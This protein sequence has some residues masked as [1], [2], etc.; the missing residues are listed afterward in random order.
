VVKAAQTP[1]EFDGA[2]PRR[3]QRLLG[4]GMGVVLVSLLSLPA[5]A[6]AA[7]PEL[8][9]PVLTEVA[10]MAASVVPAGVQPTSAPA[11][12][13]SAPA[14]TSTAVPVPADQ[15]SAPAASVAD[16]QP[17]AVATPQAS[18][19]VA[20]S[21]QAVASVPV[22]SPEGTTAGTGGVL[23]R[24]GRRA[25]APV[26]STRRSPSHVR[27][28]AVVHARRSGF[29]LRPAASAAPP[30]ELSQTAT[31]PSSLVAALSPL[32]ASAPLTGAG[33]LVTLILLLGGALLIAL[34]C[35]D[36]VGTGPRHDYLR[37]QAAH[38]WPPWR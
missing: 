15:P 30:L 24:T 35:A 21:V 28:S 7:L 22:E 19:P 5:S 10:R 37:R 38:R 8:Q 6:H 1:P 2:G 23:A 4:R 32:T 33:T 12:A 26:P 20:S 16:P 14:A 31:S 27:R 18:S 3:S 17:A 9:G 34:M 13:M 11:V 25:Q 36:A 29:T